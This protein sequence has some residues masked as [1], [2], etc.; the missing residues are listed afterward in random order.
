M[1]TAEVLSASLTKS[2]L[3]FSPMNCNWMCVLFT[4]MYRVIE[5][6]FQTSSDTNPGQSGSCSS[7]EQSDKP[8]I[9]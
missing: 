5:S 7:S 6:G 3:F 1:H 2:S 9:R 4:I 8:F